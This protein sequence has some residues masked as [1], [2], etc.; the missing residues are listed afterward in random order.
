M[1][2]ARMASGAATHRP[3]PDTRE[4]SAFANAHNGAVKSTD[5]P[6]WR[7]GDEVP[8]GPCPFPSITECTSDV[9]LRVVAALEA[10]VRPPPLASLNR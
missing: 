8:R 10:E 4:E 9:V 2:D 1:A 6:N 5:P 3:V 7:M